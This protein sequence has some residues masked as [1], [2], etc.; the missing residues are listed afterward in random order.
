MSID[1]IQDKCSGPIE[2]LR[3]L[4]RDVATYFN[5]TD[6]NRRSST[7]NAAV[8]IRALVVDLKESQVHTLVHGR[9][10]VQAGSGKGKGILD[11]F[12]EGKEALEHGAF[13]D[14]KDR[15]GKLGA[16][17]FGCDAEYRRQQ[18]AV[19]GDHTVGGRE[20]DEEVSVEF[21]VE[22]DLEMENE[23]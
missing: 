12:T 10:I 5:V 8:D 11:I 3:K 18:G 1:Y 20:A 7:V 13:R 21:D 15:T 17:V 6:P 22:A 23:I 16:D 9:K 4:S 19:V 2:L 14:W